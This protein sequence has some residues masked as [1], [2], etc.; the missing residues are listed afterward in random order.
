MLQ[1]PVLTEPAFAAIATS[2][3][4]GTGLVERDWSCRFSSTIL[5]MICTSARERPIC[6]TCVIEYRASW[7]ER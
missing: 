6:V 2:G 4:G 3:A 5:R 1:D 7:L